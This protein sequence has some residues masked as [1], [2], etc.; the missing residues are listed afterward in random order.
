MELG[1]RRTVGLVI[2]AA[3]FNLGPGDARGASRSAVPAGF[4]AQV[5]FQ[6]K[7][8]GERVRRAVEGAARRL[9][10]PACQA[11]LGD[12]EDAGTSLDTALESRGVSLRGWLGRVYFYDGQGQPLCEESRVLALTVPGSRV[13]HVCRSFV[14][15]PPSDPRIAELAVIHE[16][17]HTL[18]L[19]ENP[20]S[21]AEINRR[22]AE[23]C[24]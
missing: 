15:Q 14:E 17:L 8:Y 4:V 18:G 23:R 1:A 16:L 13:V 20:P 3:V 21:S 24:G 22:V 12:F 5:R 11:V 9:Q 7:H 6:G 19:P 10:S 2:A